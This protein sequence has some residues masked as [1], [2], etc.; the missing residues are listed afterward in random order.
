VAAETEEAR[1]EAARA[2][3]EQALAEAPHGGAGAARG[4]ER[5]QARERIRRVWVVDRPCDRR[6]R[7]TWPVLTPVI[8]GRSTDDRFVEPFPRS[9]M[10]HLVVSPVR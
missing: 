9:V 4:G 2:R 10:P 6:S 7:V 1:A 3:A 5:I 8:S